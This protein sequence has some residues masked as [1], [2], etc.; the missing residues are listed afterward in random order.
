V[1]GNNPASPVP[2]SQKVVR[3]LVHLPRAVPHSF[4]HARVR[5]LQAA[6][7]CVVFTMHRQNRAQYIVYSGLPAGSTLHTKLE[8]E[9]TSPSEYKSVTNEKVKNDCRT[10]VHVYVAQKGSNKESCRPSNQS[11]LA[12]Q[13]TFSCTILQPAGRCRRRRLLL[14]LLLGVICIGPTK[15]RTD[16][17]CDEI[18][19]K[20]D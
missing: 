4:S 1:S 9:K 7:G 15:I 19:G 18:T 3:S 2:L 10:C 5:C 14:L 16:S 20:R 6:A 8:V 11:N 17:V 12:L 13:I